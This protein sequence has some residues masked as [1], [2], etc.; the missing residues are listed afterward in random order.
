M[1]KGCFFCFFLF[2]L[3]A[4]EA[5]SLQRRLLQKRADLQRAIRTGL[6]GRW[7]AVDVAS[8]EP[9][10]RK[11]LGV[12]FFFFFFFPL[13]F[14]GFSRVFRFFRW[15][16]QIFSVVFSV[17]FSIF[18][19]CS[20]ERFFWQKQKCFELG[21]FWSLGAFHAGIPFLCRGRCI[22]PVLS[23]RRLTSWDRAWQRV[24]LVGFL[25]VKNTFWVK[26]SHS[27]WV[28][29]VVYEIKNQLTK[30]ETSRF[31]HMIHLDSPL[32][33]LLGTQSVWSTSYS[34]IF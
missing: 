25:W 4:E 6:G 24:S 10:G 18:F 16:F 32:G 20:F 3:G 9:G 26:I 14:G 28:K 33:V 2:F 1:K 5:P 13:F 21:C 17:G 30:Q 11:A 12:F 19:L 27:F 15:F 7:T 29:Q 34:H 23:S 31:W 22:L 8:G